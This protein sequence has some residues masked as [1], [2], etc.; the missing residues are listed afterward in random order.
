MPSA[1]LSVEAKFSCVYQLAWSGG[2]KHGALGESGGAHGV[3]VTAQLRRSGQCGA[4]AAVFLACPGSQR[5]AWRC[6]SL[7]F[8]RHFCVLVCGTN[9]TTETL[10][11]SRRPTTLVKLPVSNWLCCCTQ[12]VD[13]VIRFFGM[14]FIGW[15]PVNRPDQ[16]K[17]VLC[18]TERLVVQADAPGANATFLAI[19][20]SPCQLRKGNLIIDFLKKG[21]WD[22]LF[23]VKL[24]EPNWVFIKKEKVTLKT[25]MLL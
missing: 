14:H 23:S 5:D 19:L 13:Q 16:E 22:F 15:I 3:A 21:Y 6:G 11:K 20:F 17:W 12:A 7:L 10:P 9:L 24:F 25:Q 2:G 8:I 4:G 18:P 1:S